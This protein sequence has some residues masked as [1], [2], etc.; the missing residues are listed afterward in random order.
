MVSDIVG[1]C[2]AAAMRSEVPTA[3]SL[4]LPPPACCRRT[5][6]LPK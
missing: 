2:G 3:R 1:N 6:A 5:E 4:T